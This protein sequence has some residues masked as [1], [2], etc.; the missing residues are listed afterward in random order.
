MTCVECGE[1]AKPGE[2]LVE[3]YA[4]MVCRACFDA[5]G[6]LVRR[7]LA[8]CRH[9]AKA[10]GDLADKGHSGPGHAARVRSHQWAA[11]AYSALVAAEV[12][13]AAGPGVVS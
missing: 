6:R 8:K 4:G 3:L 10:A 13:A 12:R 7:A 1:A 2:V 5:P 9:H 11:T